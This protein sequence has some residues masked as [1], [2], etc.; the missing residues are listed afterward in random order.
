MN[1]A[2]TWGEENVYIAIN[3]R[4][5]ES[6]IHTPR[7]TGELCVEIIQDLKQNSPLYTPL[8]MPRLGNVA[9]D[10]PNA[11]ASVISNLDDDKL[12]E[13][14]SVPPAARVLWFNILQH[15]PFGG[16]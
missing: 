2:T 6:T 8:S 9:L 5:F 16:G 1:L 14:F 4:G 10:S 11:E 15:Y 3:W 7:G 12:H 13:L